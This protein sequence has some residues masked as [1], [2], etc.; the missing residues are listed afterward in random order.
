MSDVVT[1]VTYNNSVERQEAHNYSPAIPAVMFGAGVLGNGLALLVLFL[2]TK[3]K[4]RTV[5]YRLVGLLGVV[6]LAGTVALSPVTLLQYSRHDR[7]YGGQPLCDYYSYMMIFFGFTTMFIVA[8]MALDRYLALIHPYFYAS[9]MSWTRIKVGLAVLTAFAAIFAFLPII[10]LG[11]NVVHYPNT[12]CFFD[13]KG[14]T[15]KDELYSYSYAAVGFVVI[16]FLAFTNISVIVTLTKMHMV[17]HF[18]KP[19]CRSIHVCISSEEAQMIIFLIGVVIVFVGCW[20]PLMI[21]VVL[22]QSMYV[23]TEELLELY[24]VRLASL[25]QV[26]D[27]WVYILLRRELFSGLY[28]IIKKYICKSRGRLSVG[29]S[30]DNKNESTISMTHGTLREIECS[31]SNFGVMLDQTSV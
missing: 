28:N 31:D 26:L 6:D 25:N 7:W 14:V 24:V 22:E 8:I 10:G 20:A 18:R 12:W 17:T 29:G 11:S 5:F 13:C 23:T 3:T 16:V 9:K 15:T 21:V 30:Q 4:K 19:S 27:P 2:S 1:T